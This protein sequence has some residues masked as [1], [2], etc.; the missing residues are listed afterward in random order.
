MHA[1]SL[2][3]NVHAGNMSTFWSERSF[4]IFFL[5]TIREAGDVTLLC[6]LSEPSLL[7]YVNRTKLS[8]T[9]SKCL[10]YNQEGMAGVNWL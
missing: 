6:M 7:V 8:C 1:K 5:Y 9:S 10:E 2:S 4:H 3:L